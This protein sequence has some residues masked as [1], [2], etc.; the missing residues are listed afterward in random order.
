[1]RVHDE[2]TRAQRLGQ[3]SCCS[4]SPRRRST[5]EIDEVS[6]RRPAFGV[7]G[8]PGIPG[9]E[10]PRPRFVRPECWP[11]NRRRDVTVPLTPSRR[12]RTR[13]TASWAPPHAAR[14]YRSRGISASWNGD[15]RGR[16]CGGS[17]S[18][19]GGLGASACEIARF[20]CPGASALTTAELRRCRGPETAGPGSASAGEGPASRLLP[21]RRCRRRP[22]RWIVM[23][24]QA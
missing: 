21:S 16:S 15:G 6:V 1:M 13:S 23:D 14:R 7:V 3:A 17:M 4:T 12:R 11:R 5:P 9:A 2:L 10:L 18:R 24:V 20:R 19:S 22:A 8:R